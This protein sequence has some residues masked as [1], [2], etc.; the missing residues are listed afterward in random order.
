M[1]A[2]PQMSSRSLPSSMTAV[3]AMLPFAAASGA[4]AESPQPRQT[5]FSSMTASMITWSV[6]TPASGSVGSSASESRWATRIS[7]S[8]TR[9][10]NQS[11]CISA[12]CASTAS[13]VCWM[14]ATSIVPVGD[15]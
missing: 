7:A 9:S 3:R 1:L 12:S 4:P 5:R 6:F 15:S 14:C 13:S 11:R 10:G 2:L 8:A